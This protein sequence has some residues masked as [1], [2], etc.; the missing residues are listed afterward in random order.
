MEIRVAVADDISAILAL[1]RDVPT[2]PHWSAADYLACLNA[3]S[4]PRR[5]LL[6][7]T[8]GRQSIGFIVGKVLEIACTPGDAPEG[9]AAPVFSEITAEIE[10]IAVSASHRR[11]GSGRLLCCAMLEWFAE[12]KVTDVHLEVRAGSAG[13]IALYRGLRF[14]QQSVRPRYYRDPIEDA[15]MMHLELTARKQ[16]PSAGQ[17]EV[18]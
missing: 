9:I 7:A 12:Q 10:S 17:Q 6:V 5:R 18:R 8:R 4:R 3:D 13:A 2:A 14:A 1:E 11:R 15:L 16:R